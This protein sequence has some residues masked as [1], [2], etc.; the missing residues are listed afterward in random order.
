[1]GKTIVCIDLG[2]PLFHFEM[3][4]FLKMFIFFA[5]ICGAFVPWHRF[6]DILAWLPILEVWYSAKKTKYMIPF[7]ACVKNIKQLQS[8]SLHEKPTPLQSSRASYADTPPSLC[9]FAVECPAV[10]V[11]SR[12]GPRTRQSFV[13]LY[14]DR[15]APHWSPS[16][17]LIQNW[18]A[19]HQ[20]C[21]ICPRTTYPAVDWSEAVPMVAVVADWEQIPVC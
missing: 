2:S 15:C 13:V 20:H 12:T 11:H 16:L 1:M 6:K 17:S 8:F 10:P 14:P 9:H 4:D 19:S 7:W 3:V 5:V 18:R 21:V